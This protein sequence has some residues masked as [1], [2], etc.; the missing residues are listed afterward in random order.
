MT[1]TTQKCGLHVR[2]TLGG[3]I[4]APLSDL[5]LVN[6]TG[7]WFC[8]ANSWSYNRDRR[9]TL[10]SRAS[11]ALTAATWTE[12]SLTL[13]S[14]GS[15][16]NYTFVDGDVIEITSGTGATAGEYE[17]ASRTNDN[18]IV[19]VSSIGA[20]ADGNSDIAGTIPNNTILLPSDLRDIIAIDTIDS[21]S[22]GFEWVGGEVFNYHRTG[23][24]SFS[25]QLGTSGLIT[26]VRPNSGGAII[27]ML[28]IDPNE[29]TSEERLSLRY[30]AGWRDVTTASEVLPLPN[31]GSLDGLFLQALVAHARG[32]DKESE[33]SLPIRLSQL[34]AT[35]YWKQHVAQDASRAPSLGMLR[36]SDVRRRRGRTRAVTARG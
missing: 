11:I 32:Y 12:S 18:A 5:E 36:G 27:F 4:G 6:Q 19:L 23:R 13:T 8:T 21:N 26:G 24:W 28:E 34:A 29:S 16:A 15:F 20:A 3:P 35:P 2:H 30:T 33:M 7:E 9:A 17:I 1:L 14:T 22:E 25:N 10:F 31:D